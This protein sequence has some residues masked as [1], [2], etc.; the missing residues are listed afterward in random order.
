MTPGR[1]LPLTIALGGLA[2]VGCGDATTPR[3]TSTS[4]SG[5]ARVAV[6][7]PQ[8]EG[9]EPAIR[10]QLERLNARVAELLALPAS[11]DAE[12]ATAY[13]ELGMACHAYQFAET[14]IGCYR[15]AT[16]LD[17]DEL[18][19]T[20]YLG[21]LQAH[22]GHPQDAVAPLAR[23]LELRADYVAAGLLLGEVYTELG[24]LDD[25]ERIFAAALERNPASARAL[26]G[27]ARVDR[28]RGDHRRAAERLERALELEP[29][30]SALRYPLAMA[31]NALGDT[32]R[33][34]AN[35]ARRGDVPPPSRDPLFAEVL[36]RATGKRVQIEKGLA[37][38]RAG[39]IEEA[40]RAL[41]AALEIDPEDTP[42][43]LQLGELLGAQGRLD[44]ARAEL[45][46]AA[47]RSP[48]DSRI[49]LRLGQV[50]ALAG[51]DAG[52]IAR[53]G[54]AVE[55]HSGS[56]TAQLS[57]AKALQ[58]SGR[59]EAA[60]EH[61][62]RTIALDPSN[63][64]ARLGRALTLV[65]LRR[66]GEARTAVEADV[67]ALPDQPAFAHVLA[68]VLAA[69]PDPAVRDGAVA[70]RIIE[71]LTR[72]EQNLDLARTRAMA[73]AEVGRFDEAAQMQ[74]IVVDG[75]ARAGPGEMVE[76]MRGLLADYEA[77]RPCRRPWLDDE[78]IFSPPADGL[79]GDSG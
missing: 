72:E 78:A 47:R 74:R 21:H 63:P 38:A 36:A 45:E 6:T 7:L 71:A 77:G 48:D 11:T 40:E 44:E 50:A 54:A 62:R 14:A 46:A 58:R 28:T 32:E 33:A 29:R 25:A 65:R 76:A 69:S 19:W 70:M 15:S 13:G 57:L 41:R 66:F 8:F 37:A 24:R 30:A 18:R 4:P 55:A 12:L 75:V 42:S 31:Y 53:L 39:R 16:A 79:V 35:L 17:P 22:A 9:T 61:Y 43:R 20:Y 1:S 52:A 73:L 2:L 67:Q 64:E 59:D 49:L 56:T 51:D 5:T 68:R 60:L 3:P 27:L 10:E 34:E 26:A 23:A